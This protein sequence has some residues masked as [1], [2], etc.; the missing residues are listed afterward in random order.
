[1]LSAHSILNSGGKFNVNDV[2]FGDAN[3]NFIVYLA[4]VD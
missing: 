4:D 2:S 1:M 3:D